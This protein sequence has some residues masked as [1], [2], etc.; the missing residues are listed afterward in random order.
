MKN[1]IKFI[2]DRKLYIA[3]VGCGRISENHIKAICSFPKELNLVALCDNSLKQ[4]NKAKLNFLKYKKE[5]KLDSQESPILFSNYENL[6]KEIKDKILKID[7]IIFCTPS[8]LHPEQVISASNLGIHCC[9]EKPM[10]TN[11]GGGLR[12]VS[13]C[14]KAGVQLFVVKQNRYNKALQL[15]KKQVDNGRFGKI[16]LVNI[17]VF[18]QRPQSYY[19]NDS[20]RGTLNLDGGALMNQASHYVDLLDWLIGPVESINSSIATISRNIEVEDTAVMHLKWRRGT[21]GIM[22]VTMLT[23]PKNIEGSIT[24]LGEK[25]SVKVGGK[26]VNN[27]EFWHFDN[28]DKED[29]LVINSNYETQNFNVQGHIYYYQN[30]IEVLRGKSSPICSGKEGLKS[31]EIIIAAYRSSKNGETIKLPLE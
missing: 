28:K 3:L 21:L 5:T 9:T 12:M 20:W 25:G 8:G 18:W 10:A 31:L 29:E 7:L 14:E 22:G 26:A 23:Y 2:K 27:I 13:E 30:M 4:L 11:W 17:N 15:V 6:L 16:A 19:D 1:N 24:I